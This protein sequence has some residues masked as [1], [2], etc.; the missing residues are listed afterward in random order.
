MAPVYKVEFYLKGK[1]FNKGYMGRYVSYI[2]S[3]V[4]ITLKEAVH[5]RVDWTI[6][7]CRKSTFRLYS[8]SVV[9]EGPILKFSLE[10]SF[11]S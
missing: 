1:K 9:Q 8:S 7:A 11:T 6:E 10:Y 5:S 2:R 3:D 4:Y